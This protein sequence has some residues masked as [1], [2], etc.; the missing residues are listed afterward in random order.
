MKFES[1]ESTPSPPPPPNRMPEPSKPEQ[2]RMAE[3]LPVEVD[4]EKLAISDTASRALR[5][6]LEV[7]SAVGH[8]PQPY[9]K[10]PIEGSGLWGFMSEIRD[11]LGEVK[12]IVLA[13]QASWRRRSDRAF[14]VATVFV[15]AIIV[16]FAGAVW[17]VGGRI[18]LDAAD[19]PA[20]LGVPKP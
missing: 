10:P 14:W 6:A 16:L 9:A 18:H 11:D 5:I 7:R 15:G 3:L 19:Q 2:R 17:R 4:P 20:Q 1:R 8:P 13:S 12:Q